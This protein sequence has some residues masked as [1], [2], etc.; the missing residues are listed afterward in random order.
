[1]AF[2]TNTEEKLKQLDIKENII[3]NVK[4]IEKYATEIKVIK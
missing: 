1:M 4:S 3:K 2:V